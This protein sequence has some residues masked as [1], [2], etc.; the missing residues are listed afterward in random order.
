MAHHRLRSL[1]ALS[2]SGAILCLAFALT[3]ALACGQ[4]AADSGDIAAQL[5]TLQ[6]K[7]N[8]LQS[9][10]DQQRQWLF[11][12]LFIEKY[13]RTIDVDRVLYPN[14]SNDLV[15]GWIFSPVDRTPGKKYPGLV[16][17]HGSNHGS[18]VPEFFPLIAMAIAKGYVVIFP[19]FRGSSGYGPAWAAA[20]DYGGK[21]IEDVIAGA[22]Y[23]KSLDYVDGS[24]LGIYGISHGGMLSVL[25]LEH[26]PR[27]FKAGVD[28]VG[29]T[30]LV[31]YI[32]VKTPE[33]QREIAA[34]PVFNKYPSQSLAPYIE[35]SPIN[36]VDDIQ[37][38]L[39]ILTTTSDHHVEIAAHAGRLADVMKAHGKTYE[40]KVYDNAAGGHIFSYG[41]SPQSRAAF[42]DVFEFF[43]KYVK[44]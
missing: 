5:K 25:A 35:A 37:V 18:L 32:A 23:L 20:V 27:L 17:L 26:A 7:V 30:D 21:D 9:S 44:H 11:E 28:M 24:R 39:L 41:D 42:A 31:A 8:I 29:L 12:V 16:I 43:D 36:H 2:F 4:T 33:L 3:P 1:K 19:E 34:E 14:P 15:P 40:Y 38:P 6:A 22:D 10:Q 13:G